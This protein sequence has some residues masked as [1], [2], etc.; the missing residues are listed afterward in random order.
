MRP[1]KRAFA[2]DLREELLY[3][4]THD[5]T[6][7][8]WTDHELGIIAARFDRAVLNVCHKRSHQQADHAST[9]PG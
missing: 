5:A 6:R 4:L 9:S 3:L 1:D 2:A 8:D 7:P